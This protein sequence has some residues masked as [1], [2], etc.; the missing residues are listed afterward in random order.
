M[1]VGS[2]IVLNLIPGGVM[3]VM[4]INETDKGYKKEFLIYNGA[5]PYNLPANVS[6]TIRG[7][8]RDGYGVTE[9]AEVTAGSNLVRITVTEQMTAV[10]G[11]NI[12]ELVFIDTGTLKVSTI[13]F[14]MMVERAALNSNTVISDS[15]IA[16]AEQVLNQ[17][18]SVAAFKEQLDNASDDV[19]DL[20]DAKVQRFSTCVDMK[21]STALESGM[22]CQT[23]GYYAVNDG[24]AALY[25][26]M[27]N[28]PVSE[29]YETL[30]NGLLAV[31]IVG[32]SVSPEQFGAKGDGVTD[33]TSAFTTMIASGKKH[34]ALNKNYALQSVSFA[35][36]VIVVGNC[37]INGIMYF[38]DCTI[39]GSMIQNA[40]IHL[41][42]NNSF[43][44]REIK[45]NNYT[46]LY[47][48]GNNNEITGVEFTATGDI[49]NAALIFNKGNQNSI[50]GCSFCNGYL[51]GIRT[52]GNNAKISGCHF[53]EQTTTNNSSGIKVTSNDSGVIPEHIVIS[54]CDFAPSTEGD[55][56]DLFIG[57]RNV[58]IENCVLDNSGKLAI[59]CKSFDYERDEGYNTDD[60]VLKKCIIRN[61]IIHGYINLISYV[62][63][64]SNYIVYIQDVIIEGNMF[65]VDGSGAKI[66]IVYGTEGA[67]VK[68]N[69]FHVN[70]ADGVAVR[71]DTIGKGLNFS[72]NKIDGIGTLFR[73]NTGVNAPDGPDAFCEGNEFT[74]A[75]IASDST[76]L[77]HI[78][79]KGNVYKPSGVLFLGKNFVSEDDTMYVGT[80]IF[81][82]MVDCD[83]VVVKDGNIINTSSLMIRAQTHTITD[84]YVSGISKKTITS[85]TGTGGAITNENINTQVISSLE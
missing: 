28:A 16:Y 40:K 31:L 72:G 15:D 53:A 76:G 75:R 66:G 32:D 21:A 67:I 26:I 46:P 78:K 36:C 80:G 4:M 50:S 11:P 30:Q 9:A 84:L 41:N 22:V 81:S 5:A 17:L 68:N 1:V 13:N 19:D 62:S 64:S 8:K 43:S 63:D 74:G 45:T 34:I 7:T 56:I 59:D 47:V 77:L 65:F 57:C 70:H 79:S 25:Y 42:D 61:N 18:Q 44:V 54:E 82:A 14:I 2:P 24:G 6:A 20:K 69:I 73:L 3:P 48:D 12:F 51:Y 38:D 10:P 71:F 23:A 49:T 29:Y 58:I 27:G 60:T 39:I 55:C 37:A 35:G 52:C 33:D 83:F 85:G